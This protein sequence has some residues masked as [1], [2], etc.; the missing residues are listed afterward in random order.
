MAFDDENVRN[1]SKD[2]RLSLIGK[3]ESC[4]KTR[5]IVQ[6][7]TD[8]F[9]DERISDFEPEGT[10]HAWCKPCWQQRCDDV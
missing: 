9:I 10:L 8:R 3:C 4:G 2:D 6:L 1:W 5:Q 7:V